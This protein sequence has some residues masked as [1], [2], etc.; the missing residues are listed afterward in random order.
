MASA[1]PRALSRRSP[2]RSRTAATA[3]ATAGPA[4]VREEVNNPPCI[5]SRPPPLSPPLPSRPRAPDR[6][7][8]RPTKGAD[9]RP[10][11]GKGG[12]RAG[13]AQGK[14]GYC[15]CLARGTAG[16]VRS[17]FKRPAD[18]LFPSLSARSDVSSAADEGGGGGT[19]R[20]RTRGAGTAGTT[21]RAAVF[22][23]FISRYAGGD[24]VRRP[25]S[26]LEM[27]KAT[28]QG[29]GGCIGPV[30]PR[31]IGRRDRH[32]RPRAA[33]ADGRSMRLFHR[34]P[35]SADAADDV[36]AGFVL[37]L[38]R[39]LLLLKYLH[40]D[41]PRASSRRQRLRGSTTMASAASRAL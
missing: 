28:A 16:I 9:D 36:P 27:H 40:A 6:D 15:K 32:Y 22:I 18:V 26:P 24:L 33:G 12:G 29:H 14:T 1:A 4:P 39:L 11:E 35:R 13:R 2:R 21:S 30:P 23:I 37:F 34:F 20:V 10:S 38:C 8:G 19:V 41:A 3:A 5:F 31:V 7:D 25:P 17:S